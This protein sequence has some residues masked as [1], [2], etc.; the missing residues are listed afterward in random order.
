[1]TGKE[2]PDQFP[3]PVAERTETDHRIT[4]ALKALQEYYERR[5]DE[6]NRTVTD[7]KSTHDGKLFP[8]IRRSAD[9]FPENDGDQI[10]ETAAD[11]PL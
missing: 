6:S 8:G 11:F 5:N 1:M 2:K 7:L 3:Q 10:D 9:F 4:Q